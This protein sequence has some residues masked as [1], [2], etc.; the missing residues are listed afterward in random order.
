MGELVYQLQETPEGLLC[1]RTLRQGPH[2][3]TRMVAVFRSFSE[4]EAFISH[5]EYLS[6]NERFFTRIRVAGRRIVQ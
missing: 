6:D 3:V 1:T 2:E 4:L 5:D